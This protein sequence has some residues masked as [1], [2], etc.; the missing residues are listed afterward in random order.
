MPRESILTLPPDSDR[1]E[2]DLRKPC[3]ICQARNLRIHLRFEYEK[4]PPEEKGHFTKCAECGKMCR[5]ENLMLVCCHTYAV[6]LPHPAAKPLVDFQRLTIRGN[7]S[8]L[9]R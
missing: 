6:I 5:I 4:L 7:Y 3:P 8:H 9:F 1:N 2:R